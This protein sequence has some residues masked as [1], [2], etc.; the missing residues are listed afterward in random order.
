MQELKLNGL[1]RGDLNPLR[2]ADVEQLI[3]CLKAGWS[4]SNRGPG[5]YLHPACRPYRVERPLPVA[6]EL[7]DQLCRRGVI[8]VKQAYVSAHGALRA[9]RG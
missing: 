4:L 8:E 5:W 9:T 1:A 7:V 6:D 2:S 3:D